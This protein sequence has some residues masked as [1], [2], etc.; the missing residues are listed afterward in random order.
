MVL[1]MRLIQAGCTEEALS[2]L[3]CPCKPSPE[4]TFL[5]GDALEEVPLGGDPR[6]QGL[7]LLIVRVALLRPAVAL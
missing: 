5:C 3:P 7:Q 1:G 4:L 2:A 6:D